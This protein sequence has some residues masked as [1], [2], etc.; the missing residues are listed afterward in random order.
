M[1]IMPDIDETMDQKAPAEF[2]KRKSGC[3]WPFSKMAAAAILKMN[4]LLLNAQS[5]KFTG[6]AVHC[7]IAVLSGFW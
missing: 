7:G 3:L 1:Q 5:G 2:K 4:G 6:F